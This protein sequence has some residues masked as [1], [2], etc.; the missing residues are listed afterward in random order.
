MAPTLHTLMFLV[1]I[2]LQLFFILAAFCM[3]TD[4]DIKQVKRCAWKKTLVCTFDLVALFKVKFFNASAKKSFLIGL[5]YGYLKIKEF[6]IGISLHSW[7]F[8][9]P[10]LV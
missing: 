1:H 5:L 2:Y 9:A 3:G 7:L 4:D 10:Q 6:S 8:K